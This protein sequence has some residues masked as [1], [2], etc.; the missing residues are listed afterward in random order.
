MLRK[1][2]DRRLAGIGLAIVPSTVYD[3]IRYNLNGGGKRIRPIITLL[4]CEAVGGN[5]R[6]ALDAACAVEVLHNFTLVHDDIMDA[7][8]TRRG[9]PTIH[10]A[11][12]ANTAILAGDA[13]VA[14]AYRLLLRNGSPRNIKIIEEFTDG[15]LEVCEGQG[16]DKE[17]EGHRKVTVHDYLKMIEKKTARL[18]SA[19]STI[20]AIAGNGRPNEIA[21]LRR[22]GLHLGIAF[23]L[24]DDLLDILGNED[25]LGKA[26]GGDLKQ[27]KKTF[28]LLRSFELARGDD[29][30]LLSRVMKREV[31]T[32]A[33]I[34]RV[35]SV[36]ERTGAIDE[37][38][39]LLLRHTRKATQTLQSLRKTRASSML[40]WL[41]DDLAGRV[42]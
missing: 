25:Y 36:M 41:A 15:F 31:R 26:I 2:I 30:V 6:Q 27:G 34:R 13:M 22:Y 3:P 29:R 18:I 16:F 10:R 42:S 8:E 19:A 28:L 5:P 32:M 14:L 24:Q 20:G 7:A 12:D 40:A 11:W 17:F 39:A 33:E 21:A 4:T 35:R 38:R 23:Q 9:Q 1:R 37:A